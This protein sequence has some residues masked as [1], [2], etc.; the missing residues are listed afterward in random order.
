MSQSNF[1]S[2]VSFLSTILELQIIKYTFSANNQ[3]CLELHYKKISDEFCLQLRNN[4]LWDFAAQIS[5]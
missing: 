2:K 3:I 5:K 1:G 4:N